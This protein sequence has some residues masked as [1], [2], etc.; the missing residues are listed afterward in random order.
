MKKALTVTGLLLIMTALIPVVYSIIGEPHRFSEREC[1]RCHVTDPRGKT[2]PLPLV[3]KESDLCADCHD[4]TESLLTHPVDVIPT[5]ARVPA[6]MPLSL[7]G[8]LTCSTCHDI[9]AS[10]RT[11]F[12][13]PSHFLRR[14]VTGRRFCVTCHRES[15]AG[16]L[17]DH[18][19][20]MEQAHF[21]SRY[22][23]TD[24]SRTIDDVSSE[25]LSCH[26]GSLGRV[27]AIGVGQWSHDGDPEIS[28]PGSHPIGVSYEEAYMRS[29]KEFRPP[30]LLDRRIT[31]V[32]GQVSCLSC[33]NLYADTPMKLV[34]SNERSRLC[35][36]CHR[37]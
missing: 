24:S 28:A 6:D 18:A 3:A 7:D 34:M 15:T 22:L 27:S 31:L 30:S 14:Q 10:Y 36:S 26:D 11:P 16:A 35:L 12:G 4:V 9:H 17:I 20:L 32:N 37:K 25:C 33:H 5:H 29:P 2:G 19:E 1:L 21:K 8:R 23:V 13:T